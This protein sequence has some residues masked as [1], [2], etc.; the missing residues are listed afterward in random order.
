MDLLNQLSIENRYANSDDQL[1]YATKAKELAKKINYK[2]GL[3]TSYYNVGMYYYSTI[4]DYTAATSNYE[5]AQVL[6]QQI[7]YLELYRKTLVSLGH[8][9]NMRGNYRIAK[10]YYD[11][12]LKIAIA[13]KDYKLQATILDGIGISFSN[14]GLYDSATVYG[15]KSLRIAEKLKDSLLRE[16]HHRV[17]TNMQIILSIL[18][19]Q[20]RKTNDQQ[21]IDFIRESKSRIQSMALIHEKLYQSENLASICF[22]NYASQLMDFIYAICKIDKAQIDYKINASDIYIDMNTAVPLGL[23]INEVV[24]NSLKHGFNHADLGSINI[25]LTH[26]SSNEYKLIISDTGKGLPDN[27]DIKNSNT[28]GLKL[29]QT[30]TRQI[31]GELEMGGAKGGLCNIQFKEA[32]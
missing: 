14:Q 29:V 30:L 15:I 22:E 10:K 19:L 11:H 32:I 8:T 1:K 7:G 12:I 21:T 13:E 3:A 25:R 18:S 26:V 31:G 20:A 6:A 2:K 17:K 23:I 24:C 5:Q 28:L 9:Y 16:I 27:F 4:G